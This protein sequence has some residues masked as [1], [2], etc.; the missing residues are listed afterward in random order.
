MRT[1]VFDDAENRDTYL[2]EH[3]EA[4]ARIQQ[5]DVLRGCDDYGAGNRHFLRQRQ[6]DVAGTGR[7][8]HDQIVEVAPVGFL[9]QL[10]ECAGH[11]RS[12]PYHRRLDI[13]HE[14]DR[15]G[16]DAV[17]HHRLKR[18]TVG[19]LRPAGDAQHLWL[20]RAIDVR[21]QDPDRRALSRQR[22]RQVDGGGRFADPTLARCH[23]NDVL[24][25]GQRFD[26]ALYR[27]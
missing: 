8:I 22:Q 23:R 20:R 3:L 18:F 10:L 13:N 25:V 2:L 6:L 21:V 16:L 24:D 12:A 26:A 1:H 9:E 27:V 17:A 11:H 19:R 14:A 15:A 4:L 5:G 7:H